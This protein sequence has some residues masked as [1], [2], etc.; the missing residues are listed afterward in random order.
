M[1]ISFSLALLS[2]RIAGLFCMVCRYGWDRAH[3]GHETTG[4]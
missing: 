4:L 3:Y 2:V 1:L